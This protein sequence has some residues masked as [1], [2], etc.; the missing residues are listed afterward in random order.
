MKFYLMFGDTAWE[1]EPKNQGF[2][3]ILLLDSCFTITLLR[4]FVVISACDSQIDGSLFGLM[5]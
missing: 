5:S 4:I 3:S 1:F 2:S